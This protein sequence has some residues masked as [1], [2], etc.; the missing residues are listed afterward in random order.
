M[1]SEF[2][3]KTSQNAIQL[4]RAYALSKTN[5]L[6]QAK[7]LVKNVMTQ[8]DV[9]RTKKF[10]ERTLNSSKDSDFVT[11]IMKTLQAVGF[12]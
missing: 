6:K 9:E 11:D 7:K 4:F 2:S 5:K 1:D 8:N 12:N 3:A 10:F